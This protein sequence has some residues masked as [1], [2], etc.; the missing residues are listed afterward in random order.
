[1]SVHSGLEIEL[2]VGA[3][4]MISGGHTIRGRYGSIVI[5]LAAG[6]EHHTLLPCVKCWVRCAASPCCRRRAAWRSLSAAMSARVF[7]CAFVRWGL[8][9]RARIS[10]TI[11]ALT[12]T[13]DA[14]AERVA[15]VAQAAGE[16]RE[17][18]R[19]AVARAEAVDRI[20]P[21]L[22]Q[23][24]ERER[25]IHRPAR[26]RTRAALFALALAVAVAA[27]LVVQWQTALIGTADPT[28]GWRDH[29]WE[30]YG[31]ELKDCVTR[32]EGEGKAMLCPVLDPEPAL[33]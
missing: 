19:G 24:L 27:G 15:P 8:R 20:A 6:T 17:W 29:L 25:R 10:L 28:D 31:A 5:I 1:M 21:L 13:V 14:V 12:A 26:R 23:A 18:T 30:R 33:P 9:A 4:V 16:L 2:G 3:R 32:A 7:F 11:S 22:E